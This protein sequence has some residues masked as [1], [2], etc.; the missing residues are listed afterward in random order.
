MVSDT[1]ILSFIN[2]L[3]GSDLI[4][5]DPGETAFDLAK[6]SDTPPAPV[7]VQA[8]TLAPKS[9][10]GTGIFA[11]QKK[12]RQRVSILSRGAASAGASGS[13]KDE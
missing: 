7:I 8:R 2:G 12:T 6:P 13:S 1:S 3:S 9:G 4:K 10:S 5:E 11:A